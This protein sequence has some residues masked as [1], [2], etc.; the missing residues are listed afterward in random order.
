MQLAVCDTHTAAADMPLNSSSMTVC[1]QCCRTAVL[2]DRNAVPAAA[3]TSAAVA[4][5]SVSI[6]YGRYVSCRF[7]LGYPAVYKRSRQP[8][9][10]TPPYIVLVLQ[11]PR[12][13]L[14]TRIQ[15]HC[16]HK[17]GDEDALMA[18]HSSLGDSLEDQLSLAALHFNRGHHQVRRQQCS[19]LH[20]AGSKCSL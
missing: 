19:W 20:S 6:F 4:G 13:P 2:Y 9:L 15:F 7:S 8:H 3:A 1:Y 17:R 18:L 14:A 10:A 5:T 11:G 12:C 16:A